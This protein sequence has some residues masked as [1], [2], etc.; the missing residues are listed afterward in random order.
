MTYAHN[1][2][3]L[4]M[5]YACKAGHREVIWNSRDGITPFMVDCRTCADVA[6]H[7]EWRMDARTERH[8]PKIGDRV[9]IN[10][11]MEAA[12]AYRTEY[13]DRYWDDD[14]AEVFG[15]KEAAVERLAQG[16]VD[17]FKPFTP[18]LI[19]VTPEWLAARGR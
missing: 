14:M 13:V 2:G 15:T 4:L 8:V 12:R 9:F 16:D 19:E 10:L 17:S 18:D 1:D 6:Y 5:T 7:V 11:T 3:F